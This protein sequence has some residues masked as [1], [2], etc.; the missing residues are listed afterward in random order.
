[1]SSRNEVNYFFLVLTFNR[2]L[3]YNISLLTLTFF[4][5]NEGSSKPTKELMILNDDQTEISNALSF[6][7]K[8][9]QCRLKNIS[10]TG[11]Q[12]VLTYGKHTDK[13]MVSL[14]N[15]S[16]WRETLNKYKE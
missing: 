9:F 12:G 16:E 15:S 11:Y 8:K 7:W 3:L 10:I 2:S 1:M 6:I 13:L 5:K 4:K 14:N